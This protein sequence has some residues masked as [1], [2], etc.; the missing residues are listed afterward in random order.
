VQKWGKY[1]ET[2]IAPILAILVW[3]MQGRGGLSEAAK[4]ASRPCRRSGAQALGKAD[5]RVAE[6]LAAG[7]WLAGADYGLADIMVF[8][9][10]TRCVDLAIELFASVVEWLERMMAR[11]QVRA[12]MGGRDTARAFATMGPEVGRWG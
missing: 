11:P 7:S 1:V 3:A 8:P 10:L 6:D 12:V 5:D 2:H 4:G 9:H